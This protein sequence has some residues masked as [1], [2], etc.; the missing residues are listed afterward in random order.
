MLAAILAFASPPVAT[1]QQVDSRSKVDS[2]PLVEAGSVVRFMVEGDRNPYSGKLSRL[3]PDS[4][5][6]DRCFHCHPNTYGRNE[7]S[8]LEVFRSSNYARNALLGLLGG[9]VGAGAIAA[10][11]VSSDKCSGDLC[12]LR[13][14]AI[15]Y[16]TF[17]GALVGLFVG[18]R[19]ASEVWDPVRL[20]PAVNLLSHS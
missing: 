5:I 9:A 18:I 20:S 10:T 14:I 19:L 1:G 8:N 11:I 7:I 16:A 6:L 13:Y 4:I 12:G 3:T 2:T 17:A 15:P